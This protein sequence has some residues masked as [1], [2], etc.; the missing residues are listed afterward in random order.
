MFSDHTALKTNI[1]LFLRTA[2]YLL[3]QTALSHLMI[4]FGLNFLPL[5][6]VPFVFPSTVQSVPQHRI[7][8]PSLGG[9][10]LVH[11]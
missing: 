8:K 10:F 3:S 2:F 6:V 1:L 11:V 4:I 7:S 9:Y 5:S